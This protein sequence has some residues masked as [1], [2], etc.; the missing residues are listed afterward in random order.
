[1]EKW[2]KWMPDGNV[3]IPD[4]IESMV[5]SYEGLKITC[6]DGTGRKRIIIFLDG[7]IYA[8]RFTDEG[9]YLNTFHNLC[10]NY[11]GDFINSTSLFKVTDSAYR[12][13]FKE[14]SDDVYDVTTFT[15]YVVYTMDGAAEILSP[16]EPKIEVK[17]I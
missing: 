12:N 16:Y 3:P 1:M 11:P 17:D 14:E 15:H 5:D 10:N 13:W 4:R 9:C 8:Y 2:H 6:T 7:S